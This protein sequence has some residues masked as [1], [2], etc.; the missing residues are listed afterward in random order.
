LPF[1]DI[2]QLHYGAEFYK[3]KQ[4]KADKAITLAGYGIT[5]AYTKTE[6][7]GIYATHGQLDVLEAEVAAR[8]S[9]NNI[10]ILPTVIISGVIVPCIYTLKI[11]KVCQVNVARNK[12]TKKT[13]IAISFFNAGISLWRYSNSF[14]L[15]IQIFYNF[16]INL[17]IILIR[18]NLK[19]QFKPNLY[20]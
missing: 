19:I 14:V 6:A 16:S 10:T 17:L 18:I 20:Y 4:D 13:R 8:I 11:L 1:C 9:D 7:D 2:V 12:N 5:D 15:F 3:L